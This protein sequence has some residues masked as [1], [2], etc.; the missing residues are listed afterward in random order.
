ML[1]LQAENSSNVDYSEQRIASLV[2]AKTIAKDLILKARNEGFKLQID[3]DIKITLIPI[4]D[5]V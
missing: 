4:K 3:G 1:S 2:K 5:E